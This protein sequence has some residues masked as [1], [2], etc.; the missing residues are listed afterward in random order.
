MT[1][2]FVWFIVKQL[3]QGLDH[4]HTKNIAHC[5]IKLANILLKKDFEIEYYFPDQWLKEIHI[6]HPGWYSNFILD[7]EKI[8]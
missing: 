8:I 1:A 5:D 2:P 3:L 7:V 4:M 6:D